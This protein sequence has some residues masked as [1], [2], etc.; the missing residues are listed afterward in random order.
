MADNERILP[1]DSEWLRQ[2]LISQDAVSFKAGMEKVTEFLNKQ[3]EW[4]SPDSDG[5]RRFRVFERDWQAFLKE[6]G[7]D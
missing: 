6:N 2:A 7:L 1:A 3:Q 5:F 4:N